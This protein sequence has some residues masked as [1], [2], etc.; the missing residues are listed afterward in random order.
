L[1]CALGSGSRATAVATPASIAADA[2]PFEIS[3][4]ACAL[5]LGTGTGALRCLATSCCPS[6]LGSLLRLRSASNGEGRV[7]GDAAGARDDCDCGSGSL[8]ARE[9]TLG[10]TAGEA[11]RRE[12]APPARNG[13]PDGLVFPASPLSN[14]SSGNRRCACTSFNN[15]N[16]RWKR[17]SCLYPKSE[18]VR[19]MIWRKRARSSSLKRSATRETRARS[20]DEICRTGES[21]PATLA[22][23]VLRKKRTI[24]RAQC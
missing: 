22:T 10:R 3:G 9:V 11:V 12:L 1:A 5:D 4:S 14:S 8:L 16:S 6:A 20:S 23:T 17:C 19:S 2:S 7:N 24:W 18:W 15:P 13:D 21:L